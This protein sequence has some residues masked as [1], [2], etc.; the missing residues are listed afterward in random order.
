MAKAGNKNLNIV[1]RIDGSGN[2]RSEVDK[3]NNAIR[4][5]GK[6]A[7]DTKT[8]PQSIHQHP[9]CPELIVR[10]GLIELSSGDLLSNPSEASPIAVI[11]NTILALGDGPDVVKI[12]PNREEIDRLRALGSILTCPCRG[13]R[14]PCGSGGGGHLPYLPIPQDEKMGALFVCIIGCKSGNPL[15]ILL[16]RLAWCSCPVQHNHPWLLAQC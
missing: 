6:T 8:R 9:A 10:D 2:V 16:D 7:R 4:S 5:V 15:E 12:N 1:A 3:V 11:E 13:A 14:V